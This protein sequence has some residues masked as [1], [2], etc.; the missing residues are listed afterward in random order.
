MKLLVFAHPLE[1]I[2]FF[3]NEKCKAIDFIYQGV[4]QFPDGYILITGEGPQ[5]A[6]ECL[7]G[8]LGAFNNDI[9]EIY[10]FGVCG[11]LNSKYQDFIHNMVEVRTSYLCLKDHL[12]FK[13]HT[14]NYA[15]DGIPL[16]DCITH[17]D[18]VHKTELRPVAD[19]IDRELWSLASVAKRFKKPIR[20]IKIIS[21]IIN[22]SSDN[23]CE[24]VKENAEKYSQTQYSWFKTL[25][26][27]QTHT[28]DFEWP[29]PNYF[30]LSFSQKKLYQKL[31]NASQ[32][33]NIPFS[34]I[35]SIIK[36]F[37]KKEFEN[38]KRRASSLLEELNQLIHPLKNKLKEELDKFNDHFNG[39]KGNVSF[40]K[41]LERQ[42]IKFN[43]DLEGPDDFEAL[44]EKLSSFPHQKW[45]DFFKGKIDV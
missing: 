1:A 3:K 7:A 41:N 35:K 21:D 8:L 34:E 15:D 5:N 44:I 23:I 31:I 37:E 43:I 6:S 11:L 30:H 29:N 19:L 36:R 14:L 24:V 18:R 40:D 16:L 33:K 12:E 20:S 45:N 26:N 39:L 27:K 42:N 17:S 10:N 4:Y 25:N 13:S 32:I 28:L 38:R 2:A 9:D 22:Q